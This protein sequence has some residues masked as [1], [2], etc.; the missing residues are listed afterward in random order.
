MVDAGKLDDVLFDA[1]HGDIRERSP[2]RRLAGSDVPA[3]LGE[4]NRLRITSG[5]VHL[6]N[7][8]L[9]ETM[10]VSYSLAKSQ[11]RC[12]PFCFLSS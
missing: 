9:L 10:R 4:W 3:T 12:A 2:D 5:V 1:I 8:D 11:T 7:S 6:G